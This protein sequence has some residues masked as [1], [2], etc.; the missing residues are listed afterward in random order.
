MGKTLSRRQ[1]L[2]TA[3][4]TTALLGLLGL[5]G[6]M[7]PKVARDL[8]EL[9]GGKPP[10][11]WIQGQNCTGCS[12]SFLNSAYPTVAD[13]VLNQLSLRYHPSLRARF[14]RGWRWWRAVSSAPISVIRE[15]RSCSASEDRGT[16]D[17]CRCKEAS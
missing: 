16:R 7:T 15:P 8:E 1:F 9:A 14:P 5:L 17:G 10:V 4:A 13:L 12:V 2:K 3:S 6:T 11:I